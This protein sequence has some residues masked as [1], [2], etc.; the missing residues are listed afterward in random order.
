MRLGEE[1][2]KIRKVIFD[3]YTGVF[4][5]GIIPFIIAFF[6]FNNAFKFYGINSENLIQSL[7]WILG[8]APV[9]IL[10]AYLNAGKEQNLAVYPQ[11][12]VY[13]WRI[14]LVI[15][16]ALSWV[17]YLLAYEFMFRSFF[18]FISDSY[19]GFWPA[20]IINVIIYSL[21]HIPKGIK[22]TLGSIPFG[23]LIC[24]IT[25]Q[26][27]NILT[28]LALHIVM[29]LSNEWFSLKAHPKMKYIG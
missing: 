12:R 16:S 27:G 17:L 24:V 14:S 2:S 29:A 5:F 25:L 26:T 10:L 18:L 3:K 28:P 4:L 22:E 15:I 23:L 19:L 1:R 8:L 11:I 21:A 6:F 13:E 20:I 7:W 9:L